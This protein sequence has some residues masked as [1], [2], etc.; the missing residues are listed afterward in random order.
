MID[1]NNAIKVPGW[2]SE[3]ELTYLAEAAYKSKKIAEIGSWRGRSARAIRDNTDGHLFCVD[4]WDNNAIGIPG[5]WSEND[6]IKTPDWLLREFQKNVPDAKL[7]SDN[8]AIFSKV[9]QFRLSS[10]DAAELFAYY[11]VSFDMIFIDAGHTYKE[12]KEDINAWKPLLK[13]GGILCGHDYTD[14]FAGYGVIEAVKE[15]I[16]KFKVVDTIWTTEV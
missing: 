9:T 6:V 14:K 1:I 5:W 2:S 4:T 12:I 13:E 11:N 7:F 8:D 15:L 3:E 16:P 10:L